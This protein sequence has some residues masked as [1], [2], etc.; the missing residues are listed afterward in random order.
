MN[1]LIKKAVDTALHLMR[2]SS[3]DRKIIGGLYDTIGIAAPVA[4]QMTTTFE[5]VSL[6]SNRTSRENVKEQEATKR[7][8]SNNE[9]EIEKIKLA[10]AAIELKIAIVPLLKQ[11]SELK[12]KEAAMKKIADVFAEEREKRHSILKALEPDASEGEKT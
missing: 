10:R 11:K 7:T 3:I 1:E 6:D 4:S 5:K 8:Q 9:V 2:R 12:R